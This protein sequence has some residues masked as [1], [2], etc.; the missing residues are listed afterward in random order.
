MTVRKANIIT[1]DSTFTKDNR[2]HRP[3]VRTLAINHIPQDGVEIRIEPGPEDRAMLAENLKLLALDKMESHLEIIPVGEESFRVRG[4]L[5]ADVTQNCVIS[6]DPVTSQISEQI[7]VEFRPKPRDGSEIMQENPIGGVKQDVLTEK[8]FEEYEAGKLVLGALV[9]EILAS[10][11]DPYPR[12]RDTE[13][14][15]G[16][17]NNDDGAVEKSLSESPFAKLTAIRADTKTSDSEGA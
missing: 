2:T 13:F 7:D 5:S 12:K 8:E 17:G 6:L 15:W 16:S 10:A 1:K 9:V 11:L 4:T 3:L 14:S